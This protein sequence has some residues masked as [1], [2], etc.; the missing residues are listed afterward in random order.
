LTIRT[1]VLYTASASVRML[2]LVGSSPGSN[3]RVDS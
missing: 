3:L 2:H 1:S